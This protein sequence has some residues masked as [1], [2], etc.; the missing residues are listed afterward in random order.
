MDSYDPMATT[1][2]P[3][4]DRAFSQRPAD[5]PPARIEI[6]YPTPAVDDGRYAVKR[7]VGDTVDVSADIFRDGHDLLRAVIRYRGPGDSEPREAEM[8]RIDAHL[9]GV[10]WAGTFAVD[11]QGRWE[12]TIE[13]WTDVFGTWRDEL[14]RKVNADQHD[15]TG[16][17]SEGTLLLKQARESAQT[18]ADRALLDHAIA[19]LEDDG[20]PETAKHDVA[21]GTELHQAVERLQERHG[22]VSLRPL[23]L[24][25]DRVRARFGA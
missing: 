20:A 2:E 15:L 13:S 25:V 7:C 16:E 22:A 19:T 10:R 5:P 11:R 21:L 12:Y 14:A 9:G 8:R 4:V 17:L 23:S 18:D 1:V 3:N 24:E 6:Q